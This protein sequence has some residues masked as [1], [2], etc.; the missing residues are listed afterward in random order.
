LHDLGILGTDT[1][2]TP[3]YSRYINDFT[4]ALAGEV[5]ILLAEVGELR[6]ERQK[7][8]QYVLHPSFRASF[9]TLVV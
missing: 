8:Q 5:R 9:D 2:T 7:L 4:K 1:D 6:D 3:P